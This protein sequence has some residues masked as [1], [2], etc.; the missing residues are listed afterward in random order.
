M[1][2][3]SPYLGLGMQLA[4]SMVFFV[5]G[6][7]LLDQWLDTSPWLLVVGA[8]LGVIAVFIHLFRLVNELSKKGSPST[9]TKHSDHIPPPSNP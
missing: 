4:L 5:V 3:A 8:I 7:Y 2:E 9:R 1:H 6:G